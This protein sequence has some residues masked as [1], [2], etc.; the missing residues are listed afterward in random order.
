[1]SKT[2]LT[3]WVLGVVMIVT[4]TI[5]ATGQ[6]PEDGPSGSLFLKTV[7]VDSAAA[8]VEWVVSVEE[9]GKE[10][11]VVT[12]NLN[13]DTGLVTGDG[14]SVQLGPDVAATFFEELGHLAR[15]LDY[16]AAQ[17]LLK[18]DEPPADGATKASL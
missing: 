11:R 13:M 17:V 8:T 18:Q 3:R 15:L 2:L 5:C 4:M 12:F 16:M 14:D 9:D 1:M 10:A 6:T 7:H